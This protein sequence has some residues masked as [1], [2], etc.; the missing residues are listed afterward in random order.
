[1]TKTKALLL[2]VVLGPMLAY[3]EDPKP[4]QFTTE[5]KKQIMAVQNE[6]A[7]VQAMIA[8]VCKA[9]EWTFQTITVPSP[10]GTG[11]LNTPGC[12]AAPKAPEKPA[13]K[14]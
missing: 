12:V 1:M 9:P 10:D 11:T 3:A 4:P 5:Q 13:E 7:K 2:L 8:S 14:K 6:L